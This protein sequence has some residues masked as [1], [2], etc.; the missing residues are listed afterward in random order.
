MSALFLC[1]FSVLVLSFCELLAEVQRL[2][3]VGSG[4]GFEAQRTGLGSFTN[5]PL[6]LGPNC[7]SRVR[8]RSVR[9]GSGRIWG[10][11][12]GGRAAYSRSIGGTEC[13][14]TAVKVALW[15]DGDGVVVGVH[16]GC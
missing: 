4:V 14:F 6:L 12:W 5:T 1:F 7:R 15:G 8:G 10:V 9:V 13:S 3:H 16:E 2:F 11:G